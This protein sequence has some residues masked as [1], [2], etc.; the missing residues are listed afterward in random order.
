MANFRNYKREFIIGLID[1]YHAA[2]CMWRVPHVNYSNI[3]EKV[4]TYEILIKKLQAVDP[5]V[6]RDSVVYV[7]M[8]VC[9]YIYIHTHTCVFCRREHEKVVPSTDDCSRVSSLLSDIV[10]VKM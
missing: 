9:M 4:A 3:S 5:E 1:L 6:N 7:Y 10:C 8:C 2:G